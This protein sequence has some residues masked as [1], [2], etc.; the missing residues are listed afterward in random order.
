MT[1]WAD[2]LER[3]APDVVGAWRGIEAGRFVTVRR[4]QLDA[5]AAALVRI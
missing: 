3:D 1:H 2:E 5:V 4:T